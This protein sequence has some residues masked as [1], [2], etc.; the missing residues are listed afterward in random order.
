MKNLTILGSTG[1]IGRSAL[2]IV[3]RFPER[4]RVKAL[5]AGRNTAL[6]A[7]QIERFRPQLAVVLETAGAADLKQRLGQGS[8]VEIQVGESGYRAAAAMDGVD[9]VVSAVVGAAGLLPTLAAI[10]G[11]KDVALANKETLVMAGELVMARAASAGVR[12]LPVDSEHS[13]IFQCLAGQRRQDLDRIL[14]TASGGPF[15]ELPRERFEAVRPQD[16]LKH[17]TW[18]MGRKIT[19]DSATLMNKGLEVIEARWLFDVPPEKIEVLVHPQSIVH[20]MV[21]FRDGSVLAQL[22]VPDMKGAIAY[23]LSCPERWAL[24]QPL[25]DFSGLGGLTFENPDLRR[26]ACLGLAFD[27]CR[28]GGTL[29]AVMN[30]ANEVAVAAFLDGRIGFGAI[31]AIIA[32]TMGAHPVVGHPALEDILQADRW[33]RTVAQEAVSQATRP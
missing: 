19:I 3:A 6:L 7:E 1:S 17:P 29:P 18:Q 27:A 26:F 5:A 8:G 21:A 20:S 28:T 9:T 32:D 15:R 4:L 10:D 12:I 13:A 33:A 24:G 16:A 14:L 31:A 11:E 25:P 22:G 30:A 2:E 23:A